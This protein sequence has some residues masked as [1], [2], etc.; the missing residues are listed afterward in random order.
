MAGAGERRNRWPGENGFSSGVLGV[1][2]SGLLFVD[3]GP[4][5][6]RLAVSGSDSLMHQLHLRFPSVGLM[7]SIAGFFTGWFGRGVRRYATLC[8][9]VAS[10][11]LWLLAGFA[12]MF[13]RL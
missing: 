1:V 6:L 8:V 4:I 12:L 9:A 3:D 7:L 5:D 10:G 13:T 2:K 11:F